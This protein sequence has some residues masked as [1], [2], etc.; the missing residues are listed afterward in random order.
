LS[1]RNKA[2]GSEGEARGEGKR[3][4]GDRRQIA[5][6]CRALSEARE[7]RGVQCFGFE[8]A[9]NTGRLGLTKREMGFAIKRMRLEFVVG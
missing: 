4:E 7:R 9:W 3:G 2:W 1:G 8:Q 5:H 6:G